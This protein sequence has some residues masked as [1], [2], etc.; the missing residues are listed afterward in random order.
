MFW[1]CLSVNSYDMNNN[2]ISSFFMFVVVKRISR[3]FIL[4][5]CSDLVAK[6][7][8]DKVVELEASRG[9]LI[10]LKAR[11]FTRVS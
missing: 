5:Y 6:M 3:M 7:Q 8:H 9:S 2:A 4:L 11:D 10:W 1:D